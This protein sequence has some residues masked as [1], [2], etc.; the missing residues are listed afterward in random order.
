MATI[1]QF[2]DL[3]AW[4]KARALNRRVF[5]L[6]KNG[7]FGCDIDLRDQALRASNSVV[8]NIA[9]GFGRRT[10]PDFRRFLSIAHGSIAEVQACMLL[11]ADRGMRGSDEAQGIVGE[12]EET[13]KLIA[14]LIRY[15][16]KPTASKVPDQTRTPPPTQ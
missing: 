2:P 7:G 5:E 3:I 9:E 6:G 13:S 15:L 11:L 1:R 4:Q 14:G 12:C 16:G 8:L 10:R